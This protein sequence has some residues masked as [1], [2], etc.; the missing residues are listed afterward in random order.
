M[1]SGVRFAEPGARANGHSRHFGCEAASGAGCGRGSSLTFDGSI[2][3]L[4]TM[5]EE[6]QTE[7]R[8]AM[9]GPRFH[10]L[11]DRESRVISR[12]LV[13]RACRSLPS[14]L[15][16]YAMYSE[17]YHSSTLSTPFIVAVAL[18]VR[19]PNQSPEP[20]TLLGTS[21]AEQP[22]VPSRVVAH[23]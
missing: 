20:T 11:S 1:A 7:D 16:S 8:S 9:R 17:A 19:S 21:A 10:M 5:R 13:G 6:A 22:L 2:G 15:P 18:T 12:R 3:R 23:L 14:A 4:I